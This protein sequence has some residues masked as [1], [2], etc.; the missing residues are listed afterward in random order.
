MIATLQRRDAW[1]VIDT[2][3]KV[4][5]PSTLA[6]LAGYAPYLDDN[7]KRQLLETPDVAARL[8]VLIEWTKAH[9][10]ETEVN[11]KIA[12]DVR[13]GMEKSQR[14][15]LLRQQLNA[16][17]KELGED[18]PDGAQ[19]Y[20]TRVE[21][22]DLPEDIRKAAL[23]EVGKLE[24]GSDQSPEAGYMRTWLDTILDLPWNTKTADTTDINAAREILDADHHGLD[25]VKD[26]IVEYLAI[27]A[28]RASA[29]WRLSAAAAPAR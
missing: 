7:Q 12:D 17:R 9:I 2:V 22:A 27:R 1:Q 19:D 6:D 26:R 20:R 10:A 13:E 4:T 23:R 15:F 5:D 28:R 29:A 16:I 11:D 21:E 25:D 3:N 18:E 8:T 14:E 24:R